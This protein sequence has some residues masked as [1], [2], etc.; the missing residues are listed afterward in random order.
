MTRFGFLS[1]C[2]G[3]SG[4][5]MKQRLMMVLAALMLMQGIMV[6]M[7]ASAYAQPAPAPAPAP[8]AEG[9]EQCTQFKERK[10]WA[11][12]G[13]TI[14]N[15]DGTTKPKDDGL[16]S[17][18]YIYIKEIVG[19][20]TQKLYESFIDNT[21][22]KSAVFGAMTLMVIIF[23]V[24]FVIG[25]IQPSFGQVLVRLIKLGIIIALISPG[26]WDFFSDNMVRFFNDGT[27]E[28]VKGVTAI[29]TGV[30]ADPDATPFYQFDRLAAFLIQPDTIV[31]IMGATFAGGPYGMMMGGLMVFAFAGFIG[32]LVTAL[33]VYAVSYVARAL[34]LGLAPVFFVFLLFEKTKQLF[35]TWLNALISLSLQP[36]LLFTFLSFFMILI[37]SA[38]K[39]MLST[40][41]C[42]TEFKTGEGTANKFAFWRP[43]DKSGNTIRDE[44]GWRGTFNCIARGD[45]S[46]DEFPMNIID[47]LSFMILVYLAQRFA[48][49][50][51]RIANELANTYIAL[52]TGGRFE[53]FM[54]S[55]RGSI[56]SAAP[57]PAPRTPPG[58]DSA[59]TGKR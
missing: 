59:M 43:Q 53:Q 20:S 38:S 37:E 23:G 10:E 12:G 18:I 52:D 56:A 25:V 21:A 57:P 9:S 47:I 24:G 16:L 4:V 36:I 48:K 50:I 15:P 6:A 11:F 51:E 29:G 31:A 5:R 27:D 58:S 8:A 32:L 44:M 30:P 49:V 42:W 40:E 2:A 13:E 33:R 55:N 17:S 19:Q 28:L 3:Y 7:P 34:L 35:M 14:T 46:C 22:Y 45:E 41:F 54:S 26:G 39:D 1:V